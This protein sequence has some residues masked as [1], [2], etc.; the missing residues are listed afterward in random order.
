LQQTLHRPVAAELGHDFLAYRDL[1][2]SEDER[3]SLIKGVEQAAGASGA[4]HRSVR[5]R[6]GS[7]VRHGQLQRERLVEPQPLPTLADHRLI[8]WLVDGSECRL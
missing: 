1:A 2:F 4:G 6:I 3:Q 7:P 8:G 5:R